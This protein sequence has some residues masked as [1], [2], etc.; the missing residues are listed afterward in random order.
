VSCL[1]CLRR[2]EA[3]AASVSFFYQPALA[4]I[5]HLILLALWL[6]LMVVCDAP[7]IH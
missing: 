4:R 6:T 7:V 5:S 3:N 2:N 1:T